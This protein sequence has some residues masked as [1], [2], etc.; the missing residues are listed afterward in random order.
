MKELHFMYENHKI[1]KTT[2][3][4]RELIVE[5]GKFAQLSNGSYIISSSAMLPKTKPVEYA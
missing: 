5:T 3:A 4:G 2:F 1:F